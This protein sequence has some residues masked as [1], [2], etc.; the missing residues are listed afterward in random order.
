MKVNH[1]PV[2]LAAAIAVVMTSAVVR[3]SDTDDRTVNSI[4]S[5][6]VFKTYLKDDKVDVHSEN[7][8]VTL[9]GTVA[10][11]NERTLAENTAASLPGVTRV[12]NQ[13][14]TTGE[15]PAENSDAW[16]S[17]KVKA[18]LLVHRNVSA[19]DTKVYVTDGIV[20]LEGT[21]ASEAQKELTAEYTKDIEGVKSI[22][23]NINV[24]KD[25]KMVNKK[26]ENIDDASIT[27]QV[28]GALGAHRST[29]AIKT[30]IE[31]RDGVVTVEGKANNEAQKALV[32]K[33]VNDIKGVKGVDNK[34]DVI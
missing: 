6:Y 28:K 5:S 22:V 17:I 8:V 15:R 33:L 1:L 14:K 31:T 21:A 9:K 30:Q 11:D 25:E 23:N 13:I 7:G 18:A 12:D 27:A 26:N 2:I 4:K 32:S 34:M 29:S 20:T 19:T 24:V 16:V 3:A 10:D